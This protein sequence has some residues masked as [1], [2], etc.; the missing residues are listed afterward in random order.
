MKAGLATLIVRIGRPLG[1]TR[2]EALKLQL[3]VANMIHDRKMVMVSESLI[4][5]IL[6][7]VRA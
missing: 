5:D 3:I 6:P 7:Q 4:A 1:V 2:K